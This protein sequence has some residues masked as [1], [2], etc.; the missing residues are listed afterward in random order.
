MS[1]YS[2]GDDYQKAFETITWYRECSEDKE[3]ISDYVAFH[4]FLDHD[5]LP[6]IEGANGLHNMTP[7]TEVF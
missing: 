6:S 7:N 1:V 3:L 4:L 5:H 2:P